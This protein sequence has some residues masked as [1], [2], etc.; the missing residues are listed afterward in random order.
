MD[1]YIPDA[2]CVIPASHMEDGKARWCALRDCYNEKYRYDSYQDSNFNNV[3]RGTYYWSENN[4]NVT[5]LNYYYALPLANSDN[6][7]SGSW[8]CDYNYIQ[9]PS[10]RCNIDIINI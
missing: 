1:R 7:I 10:E 9:M 5:T 3:V 6:S 8:L 4:V 2:V